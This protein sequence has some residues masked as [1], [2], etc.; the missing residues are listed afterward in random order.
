MDGDGQRL[1]LNYTSLNNLSSSTKI[2]SRDS[3]PNSAPNKAD[4]YMIMEKQKKKSHLSNHAAA[5][6]VMAAVF[7]RFHFE[8]KTT[9]RAIAVDPRATA[10][11]IL[12][13]CM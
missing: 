13:P 11:D 6:P 9:T 10:K 7:S 12:R 2:I 4:A 1:I 5:A 3:H 8:N